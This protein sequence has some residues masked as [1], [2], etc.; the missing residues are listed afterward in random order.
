MDTAVPN[1]EKS[2][3][4][5]KWII[6]L[7]IGGENIEKNIGFSNLRRSLRIKKSSQKKN[8]WSKR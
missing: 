3:Q 8:T 2:E 7:K 4:F 5:Q 1:G 6:F